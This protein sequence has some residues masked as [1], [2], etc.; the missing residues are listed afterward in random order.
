M[1]KHPFL[2][3]KTYVDFSR[4]SDA[5]KTMVDAVFEEKT[6]GEE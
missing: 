1:L 6:S 5:F 3:E 2:K 4:E